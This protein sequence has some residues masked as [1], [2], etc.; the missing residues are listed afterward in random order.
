MA[1]QTRKSVSSVKVPNNLVPV[2]KIRTDEYEPIGA[3]SLQDSL[4]FLLIKDECLRFRKTN[5]F[6]TLKR[7]V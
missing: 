5:F 2:E 1:K 3:E 6:D 7:N 4:Y